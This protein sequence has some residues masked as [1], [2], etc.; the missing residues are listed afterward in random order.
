MALK[1]GFVSQ[2][3]GSGKTSLARSVAVEYADN[4]WSVKLA[5]MDKGQT[6][7]LNWQSRRI[8]EGI[9]PEISVEQFSN[10]SRALGVEDHFDLLI[11]DGGAKATALTL[12]IA[13]AVHLLVIPTGPNLDDLE[14]AILLAH[15]VRNKGI[16]PEKIS[17]AL[18][19]V[20]DSAVELSDAITYVDQTPYFLLKGAIPYKTAYNNATNK[21]QC[22]TETRFASLNNRAGEVIQ[23]IAD[24]A[25]KLYGD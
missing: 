7:A 20:T 3:G 14:P 15:D 18:C 11:F 6:S 16:D 17:L 10:V 9:D 23:A 1:I 21:G 19:K 25:A 8:R 13:K 24:R 5:D 4:G 2:K 12:D 22:F